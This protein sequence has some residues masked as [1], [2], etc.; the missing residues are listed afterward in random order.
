MDLWMYLCSDI[1][2]RGHKGLFFC[3]C[4]SGVKRR[5]GRARLASAWYACPAFLAQSLRARRVLGAPVSVC[6]GM[7]ARCPV[8]RCSAD[9]SRE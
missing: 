6:I 3:D 4:S 5:K 8:V 2:L 9:C 7:R 1:I